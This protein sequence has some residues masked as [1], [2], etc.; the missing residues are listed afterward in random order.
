MVTKLL[1][2]QLRRALL[3]VALVPGLLFSAAAAATAQDSDELSL[4]VHRD[5]GFGG[6]DQIQGLFTLEA[7]G[8][9][10]LVSVTFKIDGAALGEITSP[11][12]KIQFDTD[13]YPPGWHDLTAV[14]Q[15][16]DGRA[17]TST[18]RR[19]EFV[20]A[21]VAWA[22]VQRLLL[23][24]GGLAGAI[25]AIVLVAQYAPALL[26]KKKGTSPGAH[27]SYGLLGAA[28]C[29]KCHRPFPIHWWGLNAGFTHKYDRCEHC[30][31][32]SRVR[33]ATP[34]QLATAESALAQPGRSSAEPTPDEILKRQ[35][36]DSRYRD[37]V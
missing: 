21:D 20:T 37:E 34:D 35:L 33:R 24:L 19:F 28:I 30:G 7:S 5:W 22:Y 3:V 32:W 29:P 27:S 10:D 36:D 17:L 4:A 2:P 31:K 8:P 1:L 18:A 13:D 11:P 16:S 26:G 12:F 9:R 23:G 15:A 6:G 25:M 14:G